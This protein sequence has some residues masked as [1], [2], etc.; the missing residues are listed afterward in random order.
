LLFAND[1]QMK[2]A[3]FGLARSHSSPVNMTSEVV[4]R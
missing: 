2:V 4:T 3:D 1:G